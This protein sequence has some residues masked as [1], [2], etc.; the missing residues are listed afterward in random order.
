M[1]GVDQRLFVSADAGET[2]DVVP[3]NDNGQN[4]RQL[5]VI[6]RTT[7]LRRVDATPTSRTCSSRTPPR[8]G[9]SS[10]RSS[11]Y[12]IRRHRRPAP[13]STSANMESPRSTDFRVRR[14]DLQHGSERLVGD[15]QPPRR[16]EGPSNPWAREPSP[17]S[18]VVI[19]QQR[20][21]TDTSPP[22]G[23]RCCPPNSPPP[24]SPAIA[25]PVIQ[26]VSSLNQG[27]PA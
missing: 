22:P 5:F 11:T 24:A 20:P 23:Q 10:K 2:W 15:P 25:D 17:L 1:S 8:T 13:D 19:P 18:A 27:E 4:G 3:V 26:I 6:R 14:I 16:I 12:Q 21:N 9:H 7:G